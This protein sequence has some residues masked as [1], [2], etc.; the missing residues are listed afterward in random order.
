[1]KGNRSD[2]INNLLYA[3]HVAFLCSIPQPLLVMCASSAHSLQELPCAVPLIAPGPSLVLQ[4][5]LLG[6]EPVL[7]GYLFGPVPVL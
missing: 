1:M 7:E 6:P 3:L 4:G 5:P 2:W